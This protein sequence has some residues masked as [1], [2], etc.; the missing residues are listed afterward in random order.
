MLTN[1]TRKEGGHKTIKATN[2]LAIEE[3]D[4]WMVHLRV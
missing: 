2:G 1:T 3:K 4:C